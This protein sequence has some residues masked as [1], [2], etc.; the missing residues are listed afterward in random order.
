M[1]KINFFSPTYTYFSMVISHRVRQAIGDV[2]AS[3][4]PEFEA[5]RLPVSHGAPAFI[6][7]NLVR[8][9]SI[10]AYTRKKKG[11]ICVHKNL[12]NKLGLCAAAPSPAFP[13]S[14]SGSQ[15]IC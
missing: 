9:F 11:D 5:I 8:L 14:N 1:L 2:A 6:N 7:N 10:N 3:N 4:T 13:T 12:G 15:I